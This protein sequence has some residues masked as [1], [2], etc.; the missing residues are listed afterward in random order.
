MMTRPLTKNS[1]ATE[2]RPTSKKLSPR[3]AA[4]ADIRPLAKVPSPRVAAPADIRP[5][6]RPVASQSQKSA[7]RSNSSGNGVRVQLQ[8]QNPR[9]APISTSDEPRYNAPFT[10]PGEN[11]DGSAGSPTVDSVSSFYLK[12]NELASAF[13][14]ASRSFENVTKLMQEL[15]PLL[16]MER[17]FIKQV[18]GSVAE[19]SVVALVEEEPNNVNNNDETFEQ[20]GRDGDNFA[21]SNKRRTSPDPEISEPVVTPVGFIFLFFFET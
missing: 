11:K 2:S 1:P 6:T 19:E 18:D 14:D 15:G 7:R 12:W 16:L 8:T 21:I 20:D 17:G 13:K 3:V 9:Q 10:S 5:L 4:P